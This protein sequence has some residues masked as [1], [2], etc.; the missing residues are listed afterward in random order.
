MST[1]APD[2]LPTP[3]LA[4]APGVAPTAPPLAPGWGQAP[5]WTPAPAATTAAVAPA[6]RS[7][8]VKRLA[9]AGLA[10]AVV[11]LGG[12]AMALRGGS[13]ASASDRS[14]DRRERRNDDD[15]DL[16]GGD[17]DD[18]VSAGN[19][20]IDVAGAYRMVI[21][22]EPSSSTLDC[23]EPGVQDAAADVQ[24]M[25]DGTV[26]GFDQVVAAMTP[27]AECVPAGDFAATMMSGITQVLQG[28]S[29]DEACVVSVLDTFTVAD[30]VDVLASAYATPQEFV[31]RLYSTFVGCAF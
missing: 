2:Q 30:R 24:A 28:S 29:V 25:V 26:T 21:G 23:L 22:L 14:D 12:T 9:T 8:T 1:I 6:R 20:S 13:E 10:L 27:F 31:D 4:P 7:A 17:T 16:G 11:A 19:A 15:T 3:S 5:A 18:T